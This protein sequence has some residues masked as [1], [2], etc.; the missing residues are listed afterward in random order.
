MCWKELDGR[1]YF[2]LYSP[3]LTE[4]RCMTILK[5][6]PDYKAEIFGIFLW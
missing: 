5:K 4:E 2:T 1:G 6:I 3:P